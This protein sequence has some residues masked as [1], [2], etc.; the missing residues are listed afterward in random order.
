MIIY[1]DPMPKAIVDRKK[2]LYI[3]ATSL[4]LIIIVI[5]ALSLLLSSDIFLFDIFS[6]FHLQYVIILFILTPAVFLVGDKRV[7]LL[8]VLYALTVTA[9]FIFPI[10]TV[11][12]TVPGAD[13]YYMNIN[14]MNS[15]LSLILQEIKKSK[16]TTVAIVESTAEI[17][18][19]LS[20]LYGPPIV[21]VSE[22]VQSCSIFSKIAL[23]ES[24]TIETLEYPICYAR[25][26]TFDIIL[27]HP[28]PPLSDERYARQKIFF[29]QIGN[30]YASKVIQNRQLILLGD[31]NSTYYSGLYRKHFGSLHKANSYSWMNGSLL[32]LPIDQALSNFPIE[33]ELGPKLSSDHSGLYVRIR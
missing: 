17:E 5:S 7:A 1:P 14:Y 28:Y 10:Q 6:H 30:L 24:Q 16:P 3:V 31:F 18:Q 15:D 4:P 11:G 33:V 9:V 20:E 32:S 23:K 19:E 26:E 13:I 27:L 22:G 2:L 29:E 25:F 12:R 21:S 8:T